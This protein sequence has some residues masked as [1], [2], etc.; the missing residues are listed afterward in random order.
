MDPARGL[1]HVNPA[2]QRMM[3]YGAEELCRMDLEK[4]TRPEDLP[5]RLSPIEE[6]LRGER[7]S[8]RIEKRA[9]RRAGSHLWL[10]CERLEG[11]SIS[12]SAMW[13]CPG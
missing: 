9:I 8:Y 2:F 6:L 3:G 4:F 13:S 1:I 10:E 5:A 12:W 7:D 11:R